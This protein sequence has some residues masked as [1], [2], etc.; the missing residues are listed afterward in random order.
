MMTYAETIDIREKLGKGEISPE[1]VREACFA[2]MNENKRSWHTKDWKERRSHVIKDKCEQ[3]GSEEGLTL[4]HLS[5]PEKYGKYYQ[6]AY[7]HFYYIF[8]ENELGNI[9]IFVTKEDIE[10]YIVDTP[11]EVFNMCPK[12]GW[13]FR[14][15]IKKPQLVCIKCK[16][17]FNEPAQK[18]LP[19]YFDDI[20]SGSIA[21]VFD[22]PSNAPGNRKVPYIMLYSSIRQKIINNKIKQMMK[23]RFQYEIDKKSM[24]DYLEASIKYL[25]FEDTITLCKKCAFSQDIRGKNLCPV[26]KKNYKPMQYETCVDCLPDGERKNQ[27]KEWIEFGK[28]WHDMEKAL[29]ID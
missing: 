14:T 17:E 21:P 13:N 28:E 9:D 1:K 11:R 7:W 24:L 26:C 25:S 20:Y 5:H 23:D 2:D 29:G 18:P 10:S 19:E 4:Q 15:R 3:C 27:I 16:H 12:C 8:T 22:K 6:D